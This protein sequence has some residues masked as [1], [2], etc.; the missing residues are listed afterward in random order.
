M[1]ASGAFPLLA[2]PVKLGAIQATNG[3]LMASL[4]R[5]RAVR[6]FVLVL[7]IHQNTA[8]GNGV[9]ETLPS[10]E[11]LKYYVQ[12]AKA[13]GAGLIFSEAI[14]ITRQGTE[15]ANAPGIWDE[16]H[17]KGW[18]EIVDAVHA[19]GVPIVA[20]LLHVGRVAHPDQEQQKKAG[21]P[22]YAPSSVSARGGKVCRFSF[23]RIGESS[24]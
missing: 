24:D 5:N 16:V 18:K 2:K 8:D 15:W 9:D 21:R 3:V 6:E 4:T 19:E 17:A 7:C 1:A 12:R 13:G 23:S 11:S 14:L 22:V 10:E 20:Q